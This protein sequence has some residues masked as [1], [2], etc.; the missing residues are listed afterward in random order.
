MKK[1]AVILLCMC[2]LTGCSEAVYE[3]LG[4]VEHVSATVPQLCKAVMT[5]PS[6]AAVLT[7]SGGNTMY[8]CQEYSL[9]VQTLAGGDL[10][11]TMRAVSGFEKEELTVME[12]VCGDHKRYDFVWTA[13]GENGDLLCRAAVIDDGN[14]HYCLTAMA[15]AEAAGEWKEEWNRLFGSFC[16]ES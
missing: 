7:A 1:M 11:T 13:A 3:T 4:P 9:A 15:D 14:Y 8:I 5:L 2:L 16:L 6:D 10:G 12:K